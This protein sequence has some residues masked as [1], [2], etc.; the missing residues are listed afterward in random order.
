M[1]PKSKAQKEAE[2]AALA[3]QTQG[4]PFEAG[5][6]KAAEPVAA[7]KPT[8]KTRPAGISPG[9]IVHFYREENTQTGSK[10]T[11]L[12]ALLLKEADGASNFKPEDGA[13]DLKVFTKHGDEV[14]NGVMHSEIPKPAYWSWPPRV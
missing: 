5:V 12:P 11:C 8:G 7:P 14:K 10:L 13:V 1:A 9:R 2:A 4:A 3:A 6:A